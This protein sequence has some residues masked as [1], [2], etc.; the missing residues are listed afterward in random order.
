MPKVLKTVVFIL[1]G[2]AGIALIQKLRSPV[3]V[4]P[5]SPNAKTVT[6]TE[7][8]PSSVELT[9]LYD[10]DSSFDAPGS[11]Q[12]LPRGLQTLGN[13]PFR[14]EGLIQLWVRGQQVL[15]GFTAKASKAFQR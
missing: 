1:L 2:V 5:H 4:A 15:A 7:Q 3:S 9:T 8:R 12:A 14:I 10:N 13:I 6:A 11:W